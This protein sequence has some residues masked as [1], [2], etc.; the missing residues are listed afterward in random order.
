MT[1]ISPKSCEALLA[2][3]RIDTIQEVDAPEGC[4]GV[5][6]RY[7][8][9][10]GSNTIVGMRSGAQSDVNRILCDIVERLNVRFAKQK[11]KESG[12]KPKKQP[13]R[14]PPTP[15]VTQSA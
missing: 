13:P 8:I 15:A 4:D 12:E 11:A 14:R 3:F 9:S 5:W 2:P 1:H 10:Q 7:V 6:H